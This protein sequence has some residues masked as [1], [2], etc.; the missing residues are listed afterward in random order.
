MYFFKKYIKFCDHIINDEKVR[1][2]EKKF[3][4]IKN[5]SSLQIMHDIQLFLNFCSYYWRFI[6][7][8]ANICDSFY[9]LIQKAKNQKY[10]FIIIIFSIK[11]VFENIKNI[12]CFDKISTQLDIFLFFIIEIDVF[13]FDWHVVFY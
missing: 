3:E 8:F 11:N 6:K 13:D 9:A 10:K 4:Y 12:M 5:W 1:I 7:N 2:N